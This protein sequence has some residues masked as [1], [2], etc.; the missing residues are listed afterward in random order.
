MQKALLHQYRVRLEY[1]KKSKGSPDVYEVDPYTLVFH[2]GGIY[3]LGFAHNRTGMRLFALERIRGIEVTRQ[4][5]EMPDGFQPEAHF[6]SAFG[7]V[8]DTPMNVRVRFS[9]EV[10]HAV[11][12]LFPDAKVTI[13]PSTEEG[14]YY[15]FDRDR[16]F[17]PEDLELIE[18]KMK[19]I[20]SKE[21]YEKWQKMRQEQAQ[22][23][24]QRGSGQ[25]GGGQRGGG[26]QGNAPKP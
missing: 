24:R 5:F 2:K 16:P 9:A 15:D 23:A 6:A 21:Q 25:G 4:R 10:A 14:F 22:G 8:N 1:A 20:L 19:E 7:L 11:K 3:L 13:G 12:E 17:T 18:K 26:Q